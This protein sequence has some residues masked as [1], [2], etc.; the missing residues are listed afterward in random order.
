LN[1]PWGLGASLGKGVISF[2]KI[3]KESGLPQKLDSSVPIT[4]QAD[5]KTYEISN[6]YYLI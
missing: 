1:W 4:F 6:F 2:L 3:T 5:G